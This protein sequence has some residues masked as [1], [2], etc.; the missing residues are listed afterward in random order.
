MDNLYQDATSLRQIV[1]LSMTARDGAERAKQR[2]TALQDI[3]YDCLHGFILFPQHEH[4]S[5]A[6]FVDAGAV[7]LVANV[8]NVHRLYSSAEISEAQE[9]ERRERDVQT[10]AMVAQRM[11]DLRIQEGIALVSFNALIRDLW[12]HDSNL[13]GHEFLQAKRVPSAARAPR[14]AS[15]S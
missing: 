3:K 9:A 1:E 15:Q 7:A 13:Q 14:P 12:E 6:H 8:T 2:A 5:S 11:S 10:K 4:N